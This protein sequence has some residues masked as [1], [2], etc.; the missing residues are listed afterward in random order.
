MSEEPERGL[1]C[2]PGSR[3]PRTLLVFPPQWTPQQPPFGLS[4]VGGHLRSQGIPVVFRDLN[5]EFYEQIL[6]HEYLSYSKDLTL[7]RR[8]H[9]AGASFVRI[10]LKDESEEVKYD[11]AHLLRID[12]F[13][14]SRKEVWDEVGGEVAGALAAMRNPTRFYDPN[15]L[16]NALVTIDSALELASL[17][18]YPASLSLNDYRNPLCHLTLKS[19]ERCTR[20]KKSNIFIG[21][22]QD[23]LPSLVNPLPDILAISI[24]SFSQVLPGL[25]LARMLK[26]RIGGRCHLSIGGNFFGRLRERLL[27]LPRF[28]ELFCDS[29]IIGEGEGPMLELVRA[30]GQV[31]S[32][33]GAAAGAAAAGAGASDREESDPLSTVPRLLYCRDGKVIFTFEEERIKLEKIG[34][35]D[36]EGLPLQ[37]YLSPETVVC[38]QYSRGCYWGRC[39]FCDAYYGVQLEKKSIHRL[40]EEIR[41][42]RERY[43]VRHYEFID[44]CIHP[45]EMQKIAEEFMKADLGI[46]WFSNARIE[47]RFKEDI[48]SSLASS[49]LTMLLWGFESGSERIMKLIDK[50]VT[51]RERLN[52]LR[53]A[54]D[55]GIWNFAYIFF[56][57]PSETEEEAMETVKAISEHTDLIHSYGRSLFTLGKHSPLRKKAEEF[58]IVDLIEDDQDLS[59][60]LFYKVSRGM[61]QS[62]VEAFARRCT[63]ICYEAYQSPLWMYLRNRENLHLYLAKYG[64]EYVA[65]YKGYSWLQVSEEKCVRPRENLIDFQK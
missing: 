10:A 30:V 3:A 45:P 52:I 39:T 49:G 46:R 34:F 58:G 33:A 36:L 35:L 53:R 7:M 63:S 24:N 50:G 2:R 4:S 40:V 6:T 19:L 48:L 54:R 47:T 57:F 42:L 21:F 18:Y 25:T 17:P 26:E 28:F 16:V 44:E 20:D 43:G 29:L 9:L 15:E 65:S 11:A 27:A 12:E 56:G 22:Y 14:E 41:H 32:M 55:A 60:N 5:I 37:R 61:S 62:E 8:E 51:V 38:I 31:R 1:D 13:L 23:L 59:T 64:P